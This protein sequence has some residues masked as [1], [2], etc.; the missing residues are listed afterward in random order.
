[1]FSGNERNLPSAT[2]AEERVAAEERALGEESDRTQGVPGQRHDA[3]RVA[4]EPEQILLAE[5]AGQAGDA[6]V[7]SIVGAADDLDLRVSEEQLS[8]AADMIRMM[9]G[10]VDGDQRGAFALDGGADRR[11]FTGVDRHRV[12]G[13]VDQQIRIV[14]L[15]AR[16][17]LNAHGGKHALFGAARHLP[18]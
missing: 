6:P 18:S 8:Y 2:A 15:Q 9:V 12:A 7:V 3:H 10:A 4:V 1:V 17:D 11:G 16:H 5:R 13:I 14:V